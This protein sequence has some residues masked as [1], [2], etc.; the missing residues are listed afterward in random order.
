MKK[1]AYKNNTSQTRPTLPVSKI[2]LSDAYLDLYFQ[3]FKRKIGVNGQNYIM[4]F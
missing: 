2:V 3:N 4:G 1:L